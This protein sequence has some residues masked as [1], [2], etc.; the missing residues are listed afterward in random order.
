V[1][2][3]NEKMAKLPNA[4]VKLSMMGYSLSGWICTFE[5][6]KMLKPAHET[7]DLFGAHRCVVA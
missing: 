7:V 6:R 1:E 4:F 2:E 3:R 5:R